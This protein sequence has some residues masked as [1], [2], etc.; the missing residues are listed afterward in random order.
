MTNCPACKKEFSDPK[1]EFRIGTEAN[2]NQFQ[3]II[4]SCPECDICLGIT[5]K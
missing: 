1:M 2:E 5:T 3:Y 4:F